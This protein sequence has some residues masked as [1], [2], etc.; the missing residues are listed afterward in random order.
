MTVLRI[1]V[2]WRD[3]PAERIE[4]DRCGCVAYAQGRCREHL[5]TPWLDVLPLLERHGAK[6]ERV[7]DGELWPRDTGV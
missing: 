5:W 1:V 7:A 2:R 3:R 4:V 6:I